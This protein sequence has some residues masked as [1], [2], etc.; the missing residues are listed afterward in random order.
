MTVAEIVLAAQQAGGYASMFD[1]LVKYLQP[2]TVLELGTGQ[3]VSGAHVMKVLPLGSTFTTVNWS[4]PDNQVF[5]EALNPFKGDARLKM[6]VADTLEPASVDMVPAPVDLFY[7]DTHHWAWH[8]AHEM[9]LWQRI[10]CDGAIVLCDD[11]RVNDMP[12]FWD[13]LPYEKCPILKEAPMD[14]GVFR[15]DS[16]I[17]YAG[18][19]PRGTNA[20]GW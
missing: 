16:S 18:E 17:P 3:G 10:L 9:R 20:G 12:A 1:A 4:Y 7:L 8:A 2:H 5:G 14:Q 13:S 19:F 11:I 6:V 15:Y